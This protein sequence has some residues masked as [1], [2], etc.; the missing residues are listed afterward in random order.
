[1]QG[2]TGAR[3]HLGQ[4]LITQIPV[5]RITG[6][7]DGTGAHA[8]VADV[9]LAASWAARC[10]RV[11]VAW[12]HEQGTLHQVLSACLHRTRRGVSRLAKAQK[13]QPKTRTPALTRPVPHAALECS[14]PWRPP[15][16][17]GALSTSRPR[18]PTAP[19]LPDVCF[20][21]PPGQ[22]GRLAP[23]RASVALRPYGPLAYG[24][25]HHLRQLELALPAARHEENHHHGT[26]T[27]NAQE[28]PRGRFHPPSIFSSSARSHNGGTTNLGSRLGIRRATNASV[29]TMRTG[30]GAGA[31]KT[32]LRGTGYT[33]WQQASTSRM[34]H[35]S[36]H[37]NHSPCRCKLT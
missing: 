22:G 36:G 19:L 6:A 9:V 14:Q 2:R 27:R 8:Q 10:Q 16:P 4:A 35:C 5:A 23:A 25:H 34:A 30:P 12:R 18:Q 11:R 3:T 21:R 20:P 31:G 7:G 32:I 24:H 26:W 13:S 15:R 33:H 29:A 37:T 1:V 17:W 28:R